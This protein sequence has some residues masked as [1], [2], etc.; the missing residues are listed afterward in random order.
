[1]D[2]AA[3]PDFVSAYGVCGNSSEHEII[4]GLR[5]RLMEL[6]VAEARAIDCY[7]SARRETPRNY[8]K[9]NFRDRE[10]VAFAFLTAV[11]EGDLSLL[12]LL[13]ENAEWPRRQFWGFFRLQHYNPTMTR[14]IRKTSGRYDAYELSMDRGTRVYFESGY[15]LTFSVRD[16]D[17]DG[18]L[19]IADISFH[20]FQ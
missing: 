8:P 19:G 7:F 13:L 16:I 15:P 17:K 3:I 10:S 12:Y 6:E 4:V 20:E 2:A 5:E 11:E 18:D 9:I 14:P 1:M